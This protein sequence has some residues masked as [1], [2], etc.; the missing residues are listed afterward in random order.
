MSINEMTM[1]QVEERLAAIDSE[2]ESEGADLEA[3]NAEMDELRERKRSIIEAAEARRE[4]LADVA[5]GAI[6]KPIAEEVKMETRTFKPDS[7]EYRAAWLK[8][9]MGRP[10]DAEER[11][12]MSTIDVIPTITENTIINFMKNADLLKYIDFTT[13]PGPVNIP[14]YT[15]NGDAAWSS[16][17][18]QQDA[19]GHVALALYQLI[20][21]V[22][23]PRSAADMS[24]DAFEAKLAEALGNKIRVALQKAAIVGSGTGEP[25][26]ISGTV[27]TAT[28]TFTK[29]AIT[30]AD[31][32]KIMGSLGSQYQADAVWIMPTKVF[33]EAMAVCDLPGFVALSADL[34]PA[35]GGKP[36]VMDD[37]CIISSTDTVFYGC[38]KAYH[39]NVAGGINIDRD[40]SVGFKSNAVNYRAVCYGDG[41]LDAAAAFVKYTRATS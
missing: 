2:L 19:I 28:G 9:L 39:M 4:E 10:L 36:V 34:K 3:L 24:I 1:E 27:G 31:L 40:D 38:A 17:N 8:D 13:Y 16:S 26:G 22:E 18:E 15:T 7:V 23:M 14:N 6:T 29:A 21:T 35:I 11:A 12:A 32:M 5:S 41:K 25:T 20:K 30:K 37:N 33:Y